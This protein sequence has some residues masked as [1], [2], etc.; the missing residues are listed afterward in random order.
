MCNNKIMID[1]SKYY[2]RYFLI[3]KIYFQANSV[4]DFETFCNYVRQKCE[5]L[6]LDKTEVGIT[7]FRYED[8]LL[9]DIIS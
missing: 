7:R 5:E 8:C 3:M 9:S 1:F 2:K 4:R 6:K